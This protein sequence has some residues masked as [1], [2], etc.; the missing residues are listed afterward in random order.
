[1]LHPTTS[2]HRRTIL[3]TLIAGVLALATAAPACAEIQVGGG[4]PYSTEKTSLA[5]VDNDGVNDLA[6]VT[7]DGKGTPNQDDDIITFASEWPLTPYNGCWSASADNKTVHCY[8][9]K[10]DQIRI[11][12]QNGHDTFNLPFEAYGWK[13]VVFAGPG[14]DTVTSYHGW[15]EIHGGP[16]MDFIWGGEGRDKLYADG[17]GGILAGGPGNDYLNSAQASKEEDDCGTG[18]DTVVASAG[19]TVHHCEKIG[20][21]YG[22]W[23]KAVGKWVKYL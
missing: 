5:Y 11:Y 14:S 23:L 13:S 17:G 1:M 10:F 9:A 6:T 18:N 8:G 21:S 22:Q 20:G 19:D 3:A 7:I 2:R 4:N 12:G 16:G 15:D